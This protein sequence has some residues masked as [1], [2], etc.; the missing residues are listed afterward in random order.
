MTDRKH[1]Q[2]DEYYI[3]LQQQAKGMEIADEVTTRN[4]NPYPGLRPFRTAEAH[5][6]FGR[7]GQAE[8]LIS[9]LMDTRF[10][11]VLGNSGSG[12]SSLVRAGL[13]PAL[14]AGKKQARIYD[15]KIVICRPGNSPLENLAAALAGARLRSTDRHR[16]EPEVARLLAQLGDS[17]FGLLEAEGPAD[18]Q[19]KTLLIV[20]Q[21]EELFRF[22]RDIAPGPAAQ[23][24]D[25]L[26]TA[27]Q[28]PDAQVHVVITMRSEFLGECVHYRGL[29][30]IINQGQYLVPRLTNENLR[31]AIAG[32]LA[33]V[34]APVE[35]ALVNRLLRE[36][37]DDMD[38][39]PLLQH[40]LMRTYQHWQRS[41]GGRPI[42]HED[43]DA[44]GGIKKA[45]G[46]H[47]DEHYEAMDEQGRNI[48]RLLFQRLTDSSGDKGGRRPTRMDEIYGLTA[49][50]PA[51][52]AAV[53]AVIEQLRQ[54][55]TSFL[56]PP[57]G[58]S[59][60]D[61][62]M[63]DIAHESLIRNWAR[64]ADWA[65]AEADNARLYQRLQQATDDHRQ[66]ENQGWIMGALL[67]RLR[68]WQS[69][70]HFNG[71]WAARY[72]TVKDMY[73]WPSH[74]RLF[75]ENTAFLEACVE[76]EAAEKAQAAERLRQ[77]A[78]AEAAIAQAAKER[79][80]RAEAEGART[81]AEKQQ[82]PAGARGWRWCW[83][84]W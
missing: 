54:V 83:R 44:T 68:K 12:K 22:A 8:E 67:E 77:Q 50:L 70:N 45:L 20:D 31:R 61:D 26:I 62:N 33:V 27:V 60:E 66:D 2:L 57:P 53:D 37:G 48:T 80:L 63:L 78:E 32:P 76:R 28:Q 79:L 35:G 49:A 58:V 42:G 17:S 84:W 11:G 1:Y 15:W 19:Q 10:L 51:T 29:P 7:E 5:L 6:F 40:A 13:I 39:L 34:G 75:G 21:F 56:M 71:C 36:L 41:G 25:L 74:E 23:F 3:D 9:R 24:V 55:D 73:D 65:A 47:A 46:Q 64:L 30:E 72:H 18:P 59:L 52:R 81:E 69:D 16:L 82:A 14:H 4:S 38:Q 43:Y